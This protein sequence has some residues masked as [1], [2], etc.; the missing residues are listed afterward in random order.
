MSQSRIGRMGLV[1]FGLTVDK[2]KG[3][4]MFIM[5]V[6]IFFTG[7]SDPLR[8]ALFSRYLG[9]GFLFAE[10]SNIEAFYSC[11]GEEFSKRPFSDTKINHFKEEGF[12]TEFLML[13]VDEEEA[14]KIRATCEAC[15]VTHKSFNLQDIL[16][17]LI[18][19]RYPAEISIVDA[20]TLNNTQ[21][22]I[23]ILREC[24]NSDNPLRLGLEGLHSRMTFMNTLYDNLAPYALPVLWCNLAGGST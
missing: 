10:G 9:G 22:I 5:K 4:C 8:N 24:L 17:M 12:E 20:K 2:S 23:L 14:C 18:P 19:F 21:A 15:A 3:L 13:S 1:E 6:V 7:N 16:L 11:T